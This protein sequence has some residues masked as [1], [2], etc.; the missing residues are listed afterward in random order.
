MFGQ[1]RKT[2]SSSYATRTILQR[3]SLALPEI[4]FVLKEFTCSISVSANRQSLGNLSIQVGLLAQAT[5]QIGSTGC[6][7][8]ICAIALG[9]QSKT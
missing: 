6:Q 7:Q 5:V 9:Q 4:R 1:T 2:N 3:S 8:V